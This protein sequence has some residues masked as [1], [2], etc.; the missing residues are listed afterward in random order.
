MLLSNWFALLKSP[1]NVTNHSWAGSGKFA[2]CL[3][4][5][6]RRLKIFVVRHLPFGFTD[7]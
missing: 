4:P 3:Q 7:F 1:S 5:I 6:C 2:G